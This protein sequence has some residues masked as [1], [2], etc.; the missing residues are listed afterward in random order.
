MANNI[1]GQRM[2]CDLQ[3]FRSLVTRESIFDKIDA[4]A[5]WMLSGAFCESFGDAPNRA[6]AN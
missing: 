2:S 6:F 4:L 3:N 5:L 1:D